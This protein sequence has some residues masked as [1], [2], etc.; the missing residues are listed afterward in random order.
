MNGL[1]PLDGGLPPRGGG[2]RVVAAMSGGVD[3]SVAAALL[4][5]R[6]FEVIGVTMRLLP[7]LETAFGCC[8]SPNDVDDAARVCAALAVPHYVL[9]LARLFDRDV[10]Q[11]FVEDYRAGRTPNPCVDCNQRVKFGYLL[12]IARAWDA[13]AVATGH[14]ARVTDG[15]LCEAADRAKDQTYFLYRLTA[16]ELRRVLFPVGELT[17]AEVRSR[18][19]A[20]GL[21]TADKPESQEIC[22]VP[23]RDYRSFVA[24]RSTKGT[25]PFLDRA[26]VEQGDVVDTGGRKVG[27]H[28]GLVG[29]TVGQR[30]GL[31]SVV[32]SGGPRAEPL[33]V[34]RLEARTNTLVVGS[35]EETR[36]GGL[37]TGP[38][39]WTAQAPLGPFEARVRVRHRHA[40]AKAALEVLDDGRVRVRFE[41]AQRAV[42]PGQAAVF[43][44]GGE[45]LGG[46]T[47]QEALV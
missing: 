3:S 1:G 13:Q 35:A 2:K 47:I 19:R 45:V 44:S 21:P 5:E 26:G 43:Y 8:G 9:D 20:L 17:K 31:G 22:F 6:G 14:Y 30:R 27:R 15:R 38:A 32:R 4:V 11:P 25:V 40:P 16:R 29:Y 24:A 42:A 28:P 12:R 36:S 33:Y 46:G 41:E 39:S 34:V 23:G 18:A 10:I 37:V 7:K